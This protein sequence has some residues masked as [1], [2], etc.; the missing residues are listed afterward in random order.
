MKNTE[1]FYNELTK[2]INKAFNENK[3]SDTLKLSDIVS[4]FKK[5]HPTDKTNFRPL[6]VLPLIPKVFE[7]IMYDQLYEYAETFLNKLLC[8]FRKAHSTQHALFRLLQ[9]WQKVLDSSGIIGTILMD[10]SK[11]YDYLPHDLIIAK[12]EA[13]GRDTN[14]LRFLF[15]YMRCRKQRTKM[16]SSYSNEVLRGIP[17]GSVLGPLLFNIFINDIF[18]FIEKSEI[19][20]FADDNTLYSCDRN[21]L[22]IKDNL[23]FDM[24]IILF[25]FRAI[26]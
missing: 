3:F 12:L 13:Y 1:F 8:G 17:Q 20:N 9:K 19:C 6:S 24:K 15:D 7:K 14:S 4:V 21:L 16:G 2:C 11:A 18:V 26:H 10:L 22:R 23:T 5:L 25:W